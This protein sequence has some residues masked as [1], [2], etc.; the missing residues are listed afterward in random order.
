MSKNLA[1]R[2]IVNNVELVNL[3]DGEYQGTFSEGPLEVEVKVIIKENAITDIQILKHEHGLGSE[4][5]KIIANILEEQSLEV[6]TISGAT[7]SS[8]VILK[9]VEEAMLKAK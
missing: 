1:E 4:G 5:E 6:D 8:K 2:V 9:A 7:A 3:T